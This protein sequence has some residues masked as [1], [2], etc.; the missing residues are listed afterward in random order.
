MSH[1]TR[2]SLLARVGADGNEVWEEF[3]RFYTPLLVRFAERLNL[4]GQDVDEVVQAV[5]VDFF[6][7][8]AS[9]TYDRG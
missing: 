6:Q 7:A 4:Q 1:S 8:R 2:S 5:L 9:F 3:T